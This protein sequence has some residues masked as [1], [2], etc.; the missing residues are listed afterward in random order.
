MSSRSPPPL[1]ADEADDEV[2]PLFR[3]AKFLLPKK[4]NDDKNGVVV[5]LQTFK[6][7]D[8]NDKTNVSR[9]GSPGASGK[10]SC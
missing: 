8:I 7:P 2:A 6:L 9:A 1:E 10:K 4:V 3:C 5:N